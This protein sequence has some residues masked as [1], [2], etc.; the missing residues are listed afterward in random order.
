MYVDLCADRITLLVDGEE[1]GRIEPTAGGLHGLLP[2]DQCDP[3]RM[4]LT[5]PMAPFDDFVSIL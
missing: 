3:P 5:N 4:L 1:Y 2:R